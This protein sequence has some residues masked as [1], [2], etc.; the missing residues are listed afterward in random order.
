M[1]NLTCSQLPWCKSRNDSFL[2]RLPPENSNAIKT[3]TSVQTKSESSL[4]TMKTDRK[5][6][7]SHIIGKIKY[8]TNRANY[9][10]TRNSDFISLGALG[11]SLNYMYYVQFDGIFYPVFFM[12]SGARSPAGTQNSCYYRQQVWEHLHS[13]TPAGF[14]G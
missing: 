10:L 14:V 12:A 3:L 6:P 9:V 11:G 2:Q 5:V 1:M 4:K 7:I 8:D 13:G